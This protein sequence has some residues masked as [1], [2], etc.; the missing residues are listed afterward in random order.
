MPRGSGPASLKAAPDAAAAAALL[1]GSYGGHFFLQVPGKA[2]PRKIEDKAMTLTFT[3]NTDGRFNIRGVGKNSTFASAVADTHTLSQLLAPS[4]SRAPATLTDVVSRCKESLSPLSYEVAHRSRTYV[5]KP[6]ASPPPV[7]HAP[8]PP[9]PV[10]LVAAP[11][12]GADPP[13]KQSGKDLM[14]VQQAL[15][16]AGRPTP[17]AASAGRPPK[18]AP[19]VPKAAAAPALVAGQA[20]R[21]GRAR[22]APSKLATDGGLFESAVVQQLSEPLRK[23]HAIIT[24]LER[25]PGAHW[26][27]APVDAVA[28]GI[29]HYPTIITSPMDLGTVKRRLEENDYGDAQAFAS[30]V[31]LVF[32]NALTFNVLPEAPVHQAARDLYDKFEDAMRGLWKQ[33]ANAATE[34]GGSAARSVAKSG[35]KKRDLDDSSDDGVSGKRPRGAGKTGASGKKGKGKRGP[36][37]EEDEDPSA[38]GGPGLGRQNSEMAKMRKQMEALQQTIVELQ[39][40]Q[41]ITNI[42]MQMTQELAA[43]TSTTKTNKR[44]AL[45][46]KPLTFEEKRQLSADINILPPEKLGH[47]VDIVQEHMPLTNSQNGDDEIEIDIETLDTATLRHLQSYVKT[48]LRRRGGGGKRK[49]KK[50]PEIAPPPPSA[51]L[52][53]APLPSV[54]SQPSAL[55]HAPIPPAP[56]TL[57]DATPQA[58]EAMALD[59]GLGPGLES[60]DDDDDLALALG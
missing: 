38:S 7:K 11:V 60:D 18:A 30:D 28:L 39:K 23:C 51:P 43:Q 49:P 40:H 31:R 33:L 54:P 4:R 36:R 9:P 12:D 42:Q 32:R 8:P 24:N 14:R 13:R 3:I 26:F 29:L 6:L 52:P 47:V 50:A 20:K 17:R 37:E 44:A 41:Q 2:Q 10:T 5:A 16:N 15:K 55:Q 34:N 25:M 35:G 57:V 56:T 58:L 53:S 48:S 46:T 1:S 19:A 45:S 59:G 21:S 22:K 27:G